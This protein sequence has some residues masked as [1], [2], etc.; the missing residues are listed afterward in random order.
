MDCQ[1]DG[2]LI[3]IGMGNAML[4]TRLDQHMIAGNQ[5]NHLAVNIQF[6]TALK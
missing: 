4:L 6:C 5:L 1:P 3:L 2:G